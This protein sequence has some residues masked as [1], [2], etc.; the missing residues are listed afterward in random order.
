MMTGSPARTR[1]T[2]NPYRAASSCATD[3]RSAVGF[4][5][6]K[7]PGARESNLPSIGAGEA[8]GGFGSRSG[9]ACAHPLNTTQV[10]A[11]AHG[12]ASRRMARR[13]ADALQ[14]ADPNRIISR[15]YRGRLVLQPA[16]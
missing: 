9:V 11:A 16:R 12:M 13:N 3:C 8:Q 1:T 10:A 15:V 14:C 5:R 6:M 2:S 4:S 7:K